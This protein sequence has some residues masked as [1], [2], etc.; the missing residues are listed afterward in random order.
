[1]SGNRGY[2]LVESFYHLRGLYPRQRRATRKVACASSKYSD[3]Q[4][5][6]GVARP[7]PA[8]DLTSDHKGDALVGPLVDGLEVLRRGNYHAGDARTNP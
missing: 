4:L 7:R 8:Y 3:G 1:M 6:V 5:P 2:Y